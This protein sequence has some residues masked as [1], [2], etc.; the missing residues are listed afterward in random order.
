MLDT[1][2]QW[3]QQV[4]PF[5]NQAGDAVSNAGHTAGAAVSPA[6]QKMN[7]PSM[8]ALAGALGWASGFRLYAVVFLT[9]MMGKA[10]WLQLPETMH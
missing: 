6:L 7:L 2:M 8:L 1:V 4:L 3:L 10:G 9:G 5:L